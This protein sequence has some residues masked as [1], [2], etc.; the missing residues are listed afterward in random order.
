MGFP[1]HVGTTVYTNDSAA[2]SWAVF[3]GVAVKKGDIVAVAAKNPSGLGVGLSTASA[4][5]EEL[6]TA[7]NST[8]NAT[9]VGIFY[10]LADAAASDFSVSFTNTVT[11]TAILF[12]KSAVDF[13]E[14]TSISGASDP[15]EHEIPLGSV[16]SAMWVAIVGAEAGRTTSGAPSGYTGLTFDSGS[17][18]RPGLYLAYRLASANSEDPG[19][20]GPDVSGGISNI[21]VAWTLALYNPRRKVRYSGFL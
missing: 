7:G 16:R 15:P 8:S 20:F 21:K 9:R 10:A 14:G 18:S 19:V 5:W 3:S 13:T 17:G 12:R 2:T 6:G 4:G 11:A 1:S